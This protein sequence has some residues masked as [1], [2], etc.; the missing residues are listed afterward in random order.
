MT[1]T[2]LTV[3]V[4][5]VAADFREMRISNRLIASGLM[6]GLALRI[7]GEGGAG[8]VHFLVNISIPVILLFLFISLACN[9]RRR[10]QVI[11]RNAGG[12]LSMRQLLY[13]ILAAF[14][15]AAVIGLGKLLYQKRM[16]GIFGNQ[17]TLIH[18]SAMILIG[19]F[20]VVWGCAIE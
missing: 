18:F 13:V 7:L 8:I 15:T 12:F 16:A 19:Y 2:L 17:R 14:V 11:F 5:A 4:F 6:M 20:I 9:W 10:Y 1:L 3:L